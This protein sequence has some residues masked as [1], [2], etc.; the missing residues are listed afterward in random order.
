MKKLLIALTIALLTISI[1]VKADTQF[2]TAKATAYC[3]KGK[4]ATGTYV[5]EGRTVAGKPEW[6]GKTMILYEDSGD[7]LIKSEN[8]IGTYIVEDTGSKSIR[9]GKVIDVYIEDYTRA[10]QF[11]SKDVIFVLIDAEG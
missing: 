3:L 7:G 9:E 6:F 1:P 10:K 11:G 2:Y 8:Y 5:T 4:T